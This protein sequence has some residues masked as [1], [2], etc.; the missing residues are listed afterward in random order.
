[1]ALCYSREQDHDIIVR[2]VDSAKVLGRIRGVTG[3]GPR[4]FSADG[5]TLAWE[6]SD[7]L[8]RVATTDG[9]RVWRLGREAEVIVGEF[10][11]SPDGRRLAVSA[12]PRQKNKGGPLLRLWDVPTGKEIL[13]FE[14]SGR[15]HPLTFS[16]DGRMLAGVVWLSRWDPVIRVWEVATGRLRFRLAGHQDT[17]NCLA[18]SPDGKLLLSGSNDGTALV[19]DLRRPPRR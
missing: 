13:R 5:R 15:I 6:A 9:K 3:R 2:A 14:D 7:G 19:W 1:V 18:F 17:V 10:A 12:W 8:I 4:V 11:I 16:P